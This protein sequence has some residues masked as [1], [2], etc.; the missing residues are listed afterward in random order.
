MYASNISRTQFSLLE[1]Y[2]SSAGEKE[3]YEWKPHSQIMV[4]SFSPPS[5]SDT[6]IHSFDPV[7]LLNVMSL[8]STKTILRPTICLYFCLS[9]ANTS[10]MSSSGSFSVV[11][12]ISLLSVANWLMRPSIKVINSTERPRRKGKLVGRFELNILT[13]VIAFNWGGLVEN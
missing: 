3:D 7:S 1:F 5:A 4:K 2:S 13:P 10:K 6:Q 8:R 9:K 12:C 11:K